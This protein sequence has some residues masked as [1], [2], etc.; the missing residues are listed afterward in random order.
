MWHEF[1]LTLWS[2][3]FCD[4]HLLCRPPEAGSSMGGVRLWHDPPGLAGRR[5]RGT[6]L[7]I[8]LE[9][10]QNVPSPFPLSPFFSTSA[11]P[12][13]SR[14]SKA[15]V[16]SYTWQ[17]CGWRCSLACLFEATL[18]CSARYGL[19]HFIRYIGKSTRRFILRHCDW[20][21]AL[22][23]NPARMRNPVD[24]QGVV[25]RECSSSDS[26]STRCRSRVTSISLA[27]IAVQLSCQ[28]S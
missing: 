24:K 25:G 27:C 28:V 8:Y 1:L 10:N 18:I 23:K 17:I 15:G 7:F 26:W 9:S 21:L 11:H 20:F 6:W 4:A 22:M 19:S 12:T 3:W 2:F 13:L 14:S 16:E 5:W